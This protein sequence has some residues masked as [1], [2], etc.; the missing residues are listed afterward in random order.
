[1]RNPFEKLP[2]EK[3][4][5]VADWYKKARE[6]NMVPEH[7]FVVACVELNEALARAQADEEEYLKLLHRMR[8]VTLEIFE[9]AKRRRIA[10]WIMTIAAIIGWGLWL[11]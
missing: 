3:Q 11:F 7:F 1:M 9:R 6:N 10:L 5:F 4:V 2:P 8:T